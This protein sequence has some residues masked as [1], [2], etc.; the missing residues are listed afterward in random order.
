MHLATHILR[1]HHF[2]PLPPVLPLLD[3]QTLAK[4]RILELGSGTGLL[5]ILLAPLCAGYTASDRM[6]NLKLVMRNIEG[7]GLQADAGVPKLE[8]EGGVVQGHGRLAAS[9][10]PGPSL[11]S[12]PARGRVSIEEIDWVDISQD[13]ARTRLH[14]ASHLPTTFPPEEMYDLVLAVDCIY[15][16]SLVQPL[17]D[18]IVHYCPRGGGTVVW[19]VVELRSPDV[20][21]Y[22][23][24]RRYGC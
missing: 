19:V 1:Q 9:R 20:V 3:P 16:E 18:T 13:R 12:I 23:L 5:G 4:C 8:K 10:A 22:R 21:R 14:P 6:E 17:V 2:P 24:S 11:A 7:N 15:N